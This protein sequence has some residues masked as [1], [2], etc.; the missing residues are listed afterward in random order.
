MTKPFKN[1]VCMYIQTMQRPLR[2]SAY[3][4]PHHIIAHRKDIT[5][6]IPSSHILLYCMLAYQI[7]LY[8]THTMHCISTLVSQSNISNN[9]YFSTHVHNTPRTL[10]STFDYNLKF[11]CRRITQHHTTHSFLRV[12]SSHSQNHLL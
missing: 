4:T 2:M 3:I 12:R 7:A 5:P 10:L 9:S 8:H 1:C 11:N 6:H